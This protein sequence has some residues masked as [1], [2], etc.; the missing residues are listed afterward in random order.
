MTN[1]KLK[2]IKMNVDEKINGYYK[3]GTNLKVDLNDTLYFHPRDSFTGSEA[4]LSS[5]PRS[6]EPGW[7]GVSVIY[8]KYAGF[9][10][11]VLKL[12]LEMLQDMTDKKVLALHASQINDISKCFDD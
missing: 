5:K 12:R 6:S 4:N 9:R 11:N 10:P 7:L 3:I 2:E 1:S 8:A